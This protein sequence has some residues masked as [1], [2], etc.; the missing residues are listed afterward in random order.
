MATH[1]SVL[2]W[3]IPGIGEPGGLPSLG[4]DRVGHDWSDL[5]TAA[6]ARKLRELVKLLFINLTV[7]FVHNIIKDWV[8]IIDILDLKFI[9]YRKFK[10][11]N[12]LTLSLMKS[13]YH[14]RKF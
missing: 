8:F 12:Y 5:A 14:A 6:A 1:S 4:S 2:A 10:T 7:L 13:E 11:N 3:R 9:E